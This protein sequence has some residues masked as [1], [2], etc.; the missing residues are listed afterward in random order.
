MKPKSGIAGDERNI[1]VLLFLYVLQVRD[2]AF[3]DFSNLGHKLKK[4]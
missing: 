2:K 1:A 4:L 3:S